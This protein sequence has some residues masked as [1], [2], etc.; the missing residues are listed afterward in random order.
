MPVNAAPATP[1]PVEE[2]PPSSPN[3]PTLQPPI[4]QEK[5]L[6]LPLF[7]P[8]RNEASDRATDGKNPWNRKDALGE[9]HSFSLRT[10]WL[11]AA[12]IFALVLLLS[13]WAVVHAWNAHARN[14]TQAA[15][16]GTQQGAQ[17]SNQ[18]PKP[19]PKPISASPTPRSVATNLPRVRPALSPGSRADWRVI[20]FT[21]NRRTD[22]EKKVSDLAHSHPELQPAV[23]TPSG[24]APYLV[25]IG[26]LMNRDAA[27]ALAQRSRS[28]GLPHDTYAQ[29]YNH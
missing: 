17:S 16:A 11:G 26:G 27:L 10:R 4:P 3:Q 24:H 8:D 20:P 6:P 9:A 2:K 19:S 18:I 23:F 1:T 14:A 21:Y 12:G 15:D 7:N 5:Q 13:T 29:N 28:L 22:A 25:S